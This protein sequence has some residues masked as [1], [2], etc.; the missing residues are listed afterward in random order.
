MVIAFDFYLE[1]SERS[2]PTLRNR[3]WQKFYQI[4]GFPRSARDKEKELKIKNLIPSTASYP[5]ELRNN[6]ANTKV[7][8]DSRD[9][10]LRFGI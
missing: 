2:L 8:S 5:Y 1:R 6:L 3:F 9:P 7:L 10:S 4:V